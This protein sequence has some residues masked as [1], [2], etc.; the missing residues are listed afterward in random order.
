MSC[1]IKKRGESSAGYG[2][3]EQAILL[4]IPGRS[5]EPLAYNPNL[6]YGKNKAERE[7][8]GIR[9]RTSIPVSH[10]IEINQGHS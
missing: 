7:I 2:F 8:H 1:Q 4:N 5:V 10:S 9:L 3:T 6:S